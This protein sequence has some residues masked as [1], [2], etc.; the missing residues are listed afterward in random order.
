LE[1]SLLGVLGFQVSELSQS[2]VD[3]GRLG[4]SGSKEEFVDPLGP[5]GGLFLVTL[6]EG[7]SII[8]EGLITVFHWVGLIDS[9]ENSSV[10]GIKSFSGKVSSV[11]VF[12]P[13]DRPGVTEAASDAL[14]S[15]N[16]IRRAVETP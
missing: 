2:G 5:G 9:L 11:R 7:E 14:S 6:V 10:L 13:R 12:H 4:W 16:I 15:N 8:L 1:G 3:L